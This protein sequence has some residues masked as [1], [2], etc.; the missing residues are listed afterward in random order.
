M[1][2]KWIAE[3]TGEMR[4][5][6]ISQKRIAAEIGVTKEYVS[7]VLNGHRSPK[8]AEEKFKAALERLKRERGEQV[9]G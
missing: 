4:I 9:A 1:L 7:T 5:H 2:E 3:V 6:K 8:G